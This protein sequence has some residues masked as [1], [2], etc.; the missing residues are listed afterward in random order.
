MG[1][2][3]AHV[4]QAVPTTKNKQ[5]TQNQKQKRRPVCRI[6]EEKDYDV[7]NI[8]Y[9]FCVLLGQ[10]ERLGGS[11]KCVARVA[12]SAER[13]R[14]GATGRRRSNTSM[15]QRSPCTMYIA[16]ASQSSSLFFCSP[17]SQHKR[18]APYTWKEM[19]NGGFFVRSA[20]A[21]TC[22]TARAC[23]SGWILHL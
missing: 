11:Q 10:S 15:Y 18:F 17:H 21:R 9:S 19:L 8:L 23:R 14:T 5:T 22:S 16:K 3:Y 12:M 4:C 20:A 1:V 7:F 13:S 6:A 2:A